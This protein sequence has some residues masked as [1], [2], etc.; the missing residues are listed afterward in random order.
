[1]LVTFS[2]VVFSRVVKILILC[3]KDL[4]IRKRSEKDKQKK[5]KRNQ[6]VFMKHKGP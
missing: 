6:D 1:M 2:Q 4:N 5:P 3:G